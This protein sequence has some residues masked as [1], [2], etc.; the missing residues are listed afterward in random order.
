M[1][2]GLR[3]SEMFSKDAQILGTMFDFKY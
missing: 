3:A 2:S 1:Y